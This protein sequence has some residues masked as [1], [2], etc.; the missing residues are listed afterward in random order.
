VRLH[1][2]SV[3]SFISLI[4]FSIKHFVSR[5][6]CTTFEECWDEAL[7]YRSSELIEQLFSIS[8][9]SVHVDTYQRQ[10]FSEV[11]F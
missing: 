10:H 1:R 7:A 9:L 2:A 3:Y 5:T 11:C 8:S 6:N 4:V